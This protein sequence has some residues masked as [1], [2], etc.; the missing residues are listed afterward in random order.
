M[1]GLDPLVFLGHFFGS[2]LSEF[3]ASYSGIEVHILTTTDVLDMGFALIQAR[4][5]VG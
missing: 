5:Q 1:S 2:K 4:D 3:A